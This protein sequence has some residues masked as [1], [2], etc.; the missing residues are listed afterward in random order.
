MSALLGFLTSL[1][2]I[3]A[4]IQE[5]WDYLNRVSGNNPAAYIAKVGV[6]FSQLNQ[7]KTQEDHSNAAQAL[8]DALASLSK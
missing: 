8:A 3:V 6:A 2:K 4:L 1:P 7:A 5:I